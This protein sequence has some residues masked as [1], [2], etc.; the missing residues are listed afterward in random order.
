[1][2]FLCVAFYYNWVYTFLLVCDFPVFSICFLFQIFLSSF[3]YFFVIFQFFLSSFSSFQFFL[4][5]FFYFFV[6]SQFFLFVFFSSFQFF[7]SSSFYFQFPVFSIE[8]FL[9][10]SNV[11]RTIEFSQISNWTWARHFPWYHRTVEAE[12]FSD[13]MPSRLYLKVYIQNSP[14]PVS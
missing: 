8:F 1:M 14:R 2:L 5:S 3:F 11:W 7:L 4:S 13:C 12:W 9:F 6:I 10:L